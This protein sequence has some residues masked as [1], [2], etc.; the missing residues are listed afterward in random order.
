LVYFCFKAFAFEG[1]LK[2]LG[3]YLGTLLGLGSRLGG[4]KSQKPEKDMFF[5]VFVDIGS[6]LPKKYLK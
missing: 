5:K 6:W 4:L 2:A 1:L 3:V